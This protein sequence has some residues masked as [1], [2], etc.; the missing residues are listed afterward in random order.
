VYV[1]SSWT[2]G[3]YRTGKH[4]TCLIDG[5]DAAVNS[6]HV[7]HIVDDPRRRLP[8]KIEVMRVALAG[9]APDAKRLAWVEAERGDVVGSG[10]IRDLP[11]R[12]I[13]GIRTRVGQI[14]EG[15]GATAIGIGAIGFEKIGIVAT[16]DTSRQPRT[17]D[18]APR[19]GKAEAEEDDPGERSH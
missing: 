8:A 14:D 19:E 18:T 10:R 4:E 17:T 6:R 2:K 12:I 3:R 11:A 5:K 9:A 13:F 7:V 1:N 15:I 16:D